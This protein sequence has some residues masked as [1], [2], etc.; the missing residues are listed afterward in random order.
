MKNFLF[1]LDCTRAYSLPMSITAWMI[2]FAL[3]YFDGGNVV[4]GLIALAGIICAHLGANLFDD[5]IDY[6]NYLKS[7]KEK[8]DLNLKKGKCR[9]FEQN[10]LTIPKALRVCLFLFCLSLS[11]CLSPCGRLPHPL[12]PC[13]YG[14]PRRSA[15]TWQRHRRWI[16]PVQR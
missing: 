12:P 6:K 7:R 14:S 4:H 11:G 10:L 16:H 9:C 2:P 13:A 3:A 1:W 8:H 5:V 15:S